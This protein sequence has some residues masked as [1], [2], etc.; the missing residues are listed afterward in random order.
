[1]QVRASD[2]VVESEFFRGFRHD[3]AGGRAD[4]V[5]HADVG[6]ESGAEERFFSC[7]RPVDE[8]VDHDE[9]AG[10]EFFL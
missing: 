1:M 7:E 6:D 3:P 4:G 5:C 9:H 10:F 8:L 2:R